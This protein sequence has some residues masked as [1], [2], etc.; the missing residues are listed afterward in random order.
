MD[1]H[2]SDEEVFLFSFAFYCGAPFLTE[3][4]RIL[5]SLEHQ[6]GTQTPPPQSSPKGTLLLEVLRC[7]FENHSL[8]HKIKTF[9][10]SKHHKQTNEG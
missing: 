10:N 5:F 3:Q 8:D 4:I 2:A 1:K 9:D 6:W 7:S